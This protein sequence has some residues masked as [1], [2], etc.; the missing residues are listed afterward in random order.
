MSSIENTEN[1]LLYPEAKRFKSYNDIDV[2]LILINMEFY[3]MKPNKPNEPKK[4]SKPK[5]PKEPMKNQPQAYLDNL[6]A[7][8][9]AAQSKVAKVK[10][11]L[12]PLQ[13]SQNF[14]QFQLLKT[15]YPLQTEQISKTTIPLD[16]Y[17]SLEILNAFKTLETK[18]A[19]L[20]INNEESIIDIIKNDSKQKIYSFVKPINQYSRSLNPTC[21]NNT[22]ANIIS[23]YN[24]DLLEQN[25]SEHIVALAILKDKMKKS[26]S[27][28]YINLV[29]IG[30]CI[31][32][33]NNSNNKID[34][35]IT[36]NF[37]TE[38]QLNKLYYNPVKL[39]SVINTTGFTEKIALN[40][41][42]QI[43]LGFDFC[44]SARV[45]ILNMHPYSITLFIKNNVFN[46]VIGNLS[47]TQYVLQSSTIKTMDDITIYSPPEIIKQ[48]PFNGFT[49]DM[50]SIGILFYVMLKGIKA[51]ENMSLSEI[52][53][54]KSHQ[55]LLDKIIRDC[56]I[57]INSRI[58][59][60]QL[61]NYDPS[62][63]G[64]I[65]NIIF[66]IKTALDII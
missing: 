29:N 18:N 15:F 48:E 7:H 6:Q 60:Q 66:D 3:S 61:L 49:A 63:R 19:S 9:K 35:L 54:I 53:D 45:C 30:E 47:K 57:S 65:K 38:S 52:C 62:K 55:A 22:F 58:I 27:K 11:V 17:K 42:S 39:D 50:W 51:W 28:T 56:S 31:T 24:E 4:S 8:S 59:L 32:I 33:T 40:L 26:V 37:T 43:A 46:P 36:Y 13:L 5:E 41:I 2:A 14:L 1:D 34:F 20:I 21:Y 44:H 25:M 16:S 64:T 12:P 23:N 10:Q